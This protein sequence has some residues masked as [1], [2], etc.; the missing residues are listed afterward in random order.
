M[1]VALLLANVNG[2][3]LLAMAFTAGIGFMIAICTAN[4]SFSDASCIDLAKL[5]VML[6][7][8][9]HSFTAPPLE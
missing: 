8:D 5:V 9:E 4:M 7:S 3:R 1:G 6:G 2:R